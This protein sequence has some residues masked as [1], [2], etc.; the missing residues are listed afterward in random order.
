MPPAATS[1]H[2]RDQVLP[3]VLGRRNGL[4]ASERTWHADAFARGAVRYALSSLDAGIPR[5][6]VL[7]WVLLTLLERPRTHLPP[8]DRAVIER[9]VRVLLVLVPG[10]AVLT[11]FLALRH[12]RANHRHARRA[13]AGWLLDHPVA[14]ALVAGRRPAVADCLEHAVGLDTVRGWAR[15]LGRGERTEV[16][17]HLAR[18]S[19]SPD[20]AARIVE[21]AFRTG[22]PPLPVPAGAAWELAHVPARA[23]FDAAPVQPKTVTATNR[24]DLAATLVHVYRGGAAPQLLDACV[25]LAD[26]AARAL[27]PLHLAVALVL[28]ASL[29]TRGY[30]EREY[31]GISQS[32]ALKMVLERCCD[33]L[34]VVQVGGAGDPPA[35]EGPTDLAVAVLDALASAPDVVLV[36]SDGYENHHGG[37]LAR[38]VAALPGAGCA[39]PVLF[40]HSKFTAKDALDLRRPAKALPETGFWHEQDFKHMF[41]AL[42]NIVD[43]SRG[44]RVQRERMQSR[45]DELEK[46]IRPWPKLSSLPG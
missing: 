45:L 32:V 3:F 19:T 18:F 21:A 39:T 42:A 28:D 43:G 23:L 26:E 22:A 6:D 20:R 34:A 15:A 9:V 12:L 38:L 8:A 40:C 13:V 11:V 30:G 14:E 17:R 1:L 5:D 29:S 46:E 37:D 33:R 31:A 35:P 24:G 16:L 10:P 36:V 7:P 41:T 25:R 2:A 44:E 4:A 27:G